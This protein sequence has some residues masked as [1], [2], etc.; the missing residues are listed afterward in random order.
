MLKDADIERALVS[1]FNKDD[2]KIYNYAANIDL[3][4]TGKQM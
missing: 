3:E 4:E 2:A 1:F